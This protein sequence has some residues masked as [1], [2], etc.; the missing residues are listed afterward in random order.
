[1]RRTQ[2]KHGDA[3]LQTKALA[4]WD[5]DGGAGHVPKREKIGPNNQEYWLHVRVKDVEEEDS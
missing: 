5:D 4:R 1:M 2:A 3:S